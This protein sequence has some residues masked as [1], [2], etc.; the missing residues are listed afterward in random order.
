ME[1][2]EIL[3]H[4]LSVKALQKQQLKKANNGMRQK[5][6][7]LMKNVKESFESLEELTLGLNK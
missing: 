6:V 2:K 4:Y 5:T 3:S 1:F 7:K